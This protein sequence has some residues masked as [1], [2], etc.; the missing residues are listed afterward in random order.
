MNVSDIMHGTP[1][2]TVPAAAALGTIFT[3]FALSLPVF[4]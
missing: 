3:V 4:I 1:Y 2:N